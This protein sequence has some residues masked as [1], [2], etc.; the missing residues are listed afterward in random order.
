MRV[1]QLQAL[2]VSSDRNDKYTI[3]ELTALMN[4]DDDSQTLR[5]V[6]H[7]VYPAIT[8]STESAGQST[9]KMGLGQFRFWNHCVTPK[10]PEK[11]G[12]LSS[13]FFRGGVPSSLFLLLTPKVTNFVVRRLCAHLF[14]A[15]SASPR[16]TCSVT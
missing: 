10:E 4:F 7:F 16:L 2:N 5:F 11:V 9:V 13:F 1:K 3:S 8:H 12:L 6:D 14:T 15:P